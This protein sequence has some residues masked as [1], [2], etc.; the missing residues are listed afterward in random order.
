MSQSGITV[1]PLGRWLTGVG[2]D[3]ITP[4]AVLRLNIFHECVRFDR[5][6]KLALVGGDERVLRRDAE[7]R[8]AVHTDQEK[9]QMEHR[10]PQSARGGSP[11]KS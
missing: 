7:E 8:R 1:P 2:R 4:G 6:R 3:L 5:R 11:Q 9:Y 10:G